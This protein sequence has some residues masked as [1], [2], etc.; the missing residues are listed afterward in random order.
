MTYPKLG[1]SIGLSAYNAAAACMRADSSNRHV[2]NVLEGLRVQACLVPSCLG[3][4]L[5]G[6][7]EKV[8]VSVQRPATEPVGCARLS[9]ASPAD[10]GTFP[11]AS[12]YSA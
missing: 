3:R 1:A 10:L 2:A 5:G 4:G 11:L 7:K 12:M 8:I 6:L 9:A